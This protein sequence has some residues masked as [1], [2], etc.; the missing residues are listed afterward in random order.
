MQCSYKCPARWPLIL[1][2]SSLVILGAI[3]VYLIR[4][5]MCAEE[6]TVA[7]NIEPHSQSTFVIERFFS[8]ENARVIHEAL[9][10]KKADFIRK[11]SPMRSGGALSLDHLHDT[12]IPNLFRDHD[13]LKRIER[14]TGMRLQ[15]VPRNDKNQV[16]ALLY[17]EI[18]DGIDEHKDGNVY[19]GTR[20]AGI[21]VVEDDNN[22]K[23]LL[24][25]ESI[26]LEPNSLLLFEGDKMRHQITRRTETGG[27]LVLNVLLCDVCA[28]RSDPLSSL[29][30]F[31]INR[32]GFY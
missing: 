6:K 24:D 13:T 30:T 10:S 17:S 18:G 20:W 7:H 8:P 32:F 16:S 5:Q 3:I 1:A 25:G 14:E 2:C 12:P 21:Y 9:H 26:H 31:A 19:L 23:L 27:R 15:L 28:P 11:T 22:S 29:W 4:I